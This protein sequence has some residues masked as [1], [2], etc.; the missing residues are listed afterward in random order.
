MAVAQAVNT[1][2]NLGI[3]LGLPIIGSQEPI[4]DELRINA[5]EAIGLTIPAAIAGTNLGQSEGPLY[6]PPS[7]TISGAA[8]GAIGN[9][10]F[11]QIVVIETVV[12]ADRRCQRRGGGVICGLRAITEDAFGHVGGNRERLLALK[13]FECRALAL[14]HKTGNPEQ[15]ITV[16][17]PFPE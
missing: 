6:I 7:S 8:L 16:H 5:I 2:Q 11:Q 4:S 1:L 12:A 13:S 9:V 17:S 3:N 14:G 15:P 10:V